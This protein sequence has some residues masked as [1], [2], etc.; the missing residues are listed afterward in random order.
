M[1]SPRISESRAPSGS[2]T[3]IWPLSRWTT[4]STWPTMAGTSLARKASPS[5]TPTATPP[6]SPSTCR[7]QQPRAVRLMATIA[8]VFEAVWPR[9]GPR[10]SRCCSDGARDALLPPGRCRWRRCSRP[11]LARRAAHGSSPRCRSARQD[12]LGRAAVRMRVSFARLA[13]G[14]PAR[15]ADAGLP[16]RG[17]LRGLRRTRLSTPCAWR[18]ADHAVRIDDGESRRVVSREQSQPPQTLQQ[19]RRRLVPSRSDRHTKRPSRCSRYIAHP[20]SR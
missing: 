17:C 8:R 7:H 10:C 12:L 20:R 5:R 2:T 6:A 18:N 1:R 9:P 14:R 13:V 4:S 15:T 11:P 19:D 3:A 16:R